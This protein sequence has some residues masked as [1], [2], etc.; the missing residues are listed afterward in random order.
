MA[1]AILTSAAAA[2]FDELPKPIQN[3]V[4]LILER[5]RNWPN[6]SGAKPLRGNLAGHYRMRTGDYRLQFRVAAR[7]CWLSGWVTATS[8]M[9]TKGGKM[10]AQN[11]NLDGNSYVVLSRADYDELTTL[12][13]AAEFPALPQPDAEGNYPAVEYARASIARGIIRGRAK[14]GLSQ[15]ELARRASVRFETLCRIE[16][17]KVTPSVASIEKIDRALKQAQATMN[18]NRTG[19][20][21][22]RRKSAGKRRR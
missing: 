13:K 6:V 9:T 21:S 2:Q 5:L 7:R 14:C 4:L 15:R 10:G 22:K 18:A 3:R 11:I 19:S 20:A 12:A 17:G 16:T 1:E 8:S